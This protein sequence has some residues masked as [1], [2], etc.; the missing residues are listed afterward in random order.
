MHPSVS[1][2]KE[3]VKNISV[4]TGSSLSVP[5]ALSTIRESDNIIRAKNGQV[6]IIGGLMQNTVVN[7]VSKVPF[8]GDLPLLG[9]LFRHTLEVKKK[10]ELVILLKPIVVES[11]GQMEEYVQRTKSRFKNISLE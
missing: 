6:V 5:L 11:D 7:E 10:S 4:S 2:V 8:L 9:G 3:K 1:S